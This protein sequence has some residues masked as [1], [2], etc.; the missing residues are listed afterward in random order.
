MTAG[1]VVAGQAPASAG[2]GSVRPPTGPDVLRGFRRPG[3]ET[4]AGFR[5][6]WPHGAVD[7]K[8]IAREVDQVAAAG[9]GA[10]EIADVTHSLS[11]RGITI[12][13]E[14]QGWGT[15]SWVAGVKAAL[16]RASRHGI[17]VDITIGPSWPAAVPTVTPDDD[18]ACSELAHGQAIVAGGTTYDA[19]LPDPV[20]APESEST[21]RHLV[22][23][24]AFLTVGAPVKGVQTLDPSTYVDLTDSVV[25]GRLTWTAPADGVGPD[26]PLASR[27]GAG[28]RGRP[29]HLPAVLR[30]R[31]LQRRRLGR[32]HRLLEDPHPRLHPAPAAREGGRLPL[33]G[34]A[35]DRDRRDHLDAADARGV[36]A[37]GGY[38]LLP[39]LPVVLEVN[40][41]YVFASTPHHDPG[42]RRLQ[43][44]AVR[45]L[46]RLPPAAGAGL[47]ALARHGPAGAALRPR[48]RHRRARR[49]ARR[50]RDR[51][52]RLQEPRRLPGDVRRP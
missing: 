16:D 52:A 3:P 31:P 15:A 48:D 8:E 20:V 9:F 14:K 34:L 6:W 10:L 32:G 19:A 40:E 18:A 21:A 4:A 38:D 46:P 5:W 45:P 22:A 37:P 13:L 39:Y 30:R 35:G 2:P 25:D 28:A 24:Q 26:R 1:V 41:K 7:P 36:P 12:D 17:R 29:A 11:A 51:V 49:A 43:P 33:R 44:G 23:V 42:P 47:R 50:A 27:L